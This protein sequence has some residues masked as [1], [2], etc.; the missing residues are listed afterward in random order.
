MPPTTL[1]ARAIYEKG[2]LRP[3]VPLP[4]IEETEVELEIS[5]PQ[6]ISADD[7][8][9]SETIAEARK[10]KRPS[11]TLDEL[12]AITSQIPGSMADDIIAM[13]EDRL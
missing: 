5:T 10:R 3:L 6:S 2:I 4:L 12:L 11:I 1:K 8:T 9:D 7:L 13:R